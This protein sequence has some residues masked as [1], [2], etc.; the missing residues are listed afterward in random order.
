MNRQQPHLER[1]EKIATILCTSGAKVVEELS[2]CYLENAE[3]LGKL[4]VF[5]FAMGE[6]FGEVSL[7]SDYSVTIR[8][9]PRDN[10]HLARKEFKL[11]ITEADPGYCGDDEVCYLNPAT[12]LVPNRATVSGSVFPRQQRARINVVQSCDTHGLRIDVFSVMLISKELSEG[13]PTV[14]VAQQLRDREE[15]KFSFQTLP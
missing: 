1:T 3:S 11:K 13:A 5:K 4:E 12:A 7:E 8:C 15:R 9:T 10:D 14:V 2:R 6:V